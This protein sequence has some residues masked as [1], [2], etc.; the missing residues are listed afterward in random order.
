MNVWVLAL[1]LIVL[2]L[3]QNFILRHFALR[4][5]KYARRFSVPAAFEGETVHLTE[6]LRNDRPLFI[7]WLRAE[8]RLSPYLRFGRQ[9][10]LAVRGE[11]YHKSVFT[12]R[13]FQ[14]IT[15]RHTVTLLH[16]GA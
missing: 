4:G 10:N 8:S 5:L 12:L 13:P 15:R 16:R 14:Q 2:A 9:E 7:P 1:A 11:M 3:L 6:V